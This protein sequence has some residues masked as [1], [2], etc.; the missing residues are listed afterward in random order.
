MPN[1]SARS[2][3]HLDANGIVIVGSEVDTGDILVG[4][5]SPKGEDNP[6]AEEKLMAAI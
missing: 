3:A 5:T 6:T 4:R 2:R 1:A